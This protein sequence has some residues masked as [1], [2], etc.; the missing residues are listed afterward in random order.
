M[1]PSADFRLFLAV[2]CAGFAAG[3]GAAALT[4]V[5]HFAEFLAFGRAKSDFGVILDQVS[6]FRR[7]AAVL[8]CGAIASVG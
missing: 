8:A 3:T 7:F 1:Q 6:A 4:E 5:I 2:L